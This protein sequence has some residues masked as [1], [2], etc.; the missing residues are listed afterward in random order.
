MSLSLH[1]AQGNARRVAGKKGPAK[2]P[3][4]D[5][6]V[7]VALRR[8]LITRIRG[9]DQYMKARRETHHHP[10]A[11]YKQPITES[12][13]MRSNG[14][15]SPVVFKAI[16][17]R[18]RVQLWNRQASIIKDLTTLTLRPERRYLPRV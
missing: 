5:Q 11:L 7:A 3:A 14:I 17:Y 12:P 2:L 15:T 13:T 18:R 8:G 16:R 9:S 4:R 10:P 1:I 6:C